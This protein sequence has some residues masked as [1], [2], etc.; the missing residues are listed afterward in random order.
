[1]SANEQ[2][3]TLEGVIVGNKE[4]SAGSEVEVIC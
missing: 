1:M 3:E 4:G 2:P